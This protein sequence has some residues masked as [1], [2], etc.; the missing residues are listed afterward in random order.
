VLHPDAVSPDRNLN[1]E[2]LLGDDDEPVRPLGA[3][4]FGYDQLH[5]FDPDETVHDRFLCL[6]ISELLRK[7]RGGWDPADL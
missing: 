2:D 6:G 7:Y 4:I 3:R 1:D 5:R